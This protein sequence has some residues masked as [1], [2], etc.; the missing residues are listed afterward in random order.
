M[1]ASSEVCV[2]ARA[3]QADVSRRA[4]AGAVAWQVPGTG[5]YETSR[6]F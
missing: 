2:A 5:G 3:D 6:S 1:E 4:I